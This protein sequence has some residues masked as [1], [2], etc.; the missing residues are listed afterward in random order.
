M[1]VTA[2][3]VKETLYPLEPENVHRVRLP[4][5]EGGGRRALERRLPSV[6]ILSISRGSAAGTVLR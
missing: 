2:E 5:S 4:R 3:V 1:R 6:V